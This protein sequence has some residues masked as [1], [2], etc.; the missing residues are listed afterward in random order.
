MFVY[1]TVSPLS[2]FFICIQELHYRYAQ[3]KRLFTKDVR[4]NLGFT[5]RPLRMRQTI[6]FLPTIIFSV[7]HREFVSWKT[8][9]L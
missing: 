4:Q 8:A 1:N 9:T 6:I 7:T 5:T 3:A 2:R